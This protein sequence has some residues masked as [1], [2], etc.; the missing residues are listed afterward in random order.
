[1][2]GFAGGA[3]CTYA[4]D[5]LMQ[6]LQSA[7]LQGGGTTIRR[8]DVTYDVA[9]RVTG[10]RDQMPG[11]T[12]TRSFRYDGANRLIQATMS[13][14]DGGPVLRDDRYAYSPSG[15]LIRSDEALTGAMVYGDAARAGLLTRVQ[16]AGALAPSDIVYDAAGRPTDLGTAH[17]LAYDAW[18][19]L[20]SATLPD[21]T[22]VG[23]A[24]D[25][26]GKRVRKTVHRAGGDEITHY[27]EALYD[28]GPQGTRISVYPAK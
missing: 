20:I 14:A 11:N 6:R 5:P 3:A 16:H 10:W 24:Y 1:R 9:G 21:G 28:S 17:G 22:V 4:H 26:S 2:I 12:L 8:I 19:R 23:F 25:H 18:D 27:A 13:P 7:T 15:N